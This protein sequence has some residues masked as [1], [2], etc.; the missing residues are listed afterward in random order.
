MTDKIEELTK[1][2]EELK[3]A[4]AFLLTRVDVDDRD[5]ELEEH[6]EK[7]WGYSWMKYQGRDAEEEARLDRIYRE[8]LQTTY[9]VRPDGKK[10]QMP[11]HCWPPMPKELRGIY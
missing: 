3:E 1:Q 10:R 9:E 8:W 5:P 7:I 2:I 6:F 11:K 4:V